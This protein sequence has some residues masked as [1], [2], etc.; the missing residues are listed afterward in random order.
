MP[1]NTNSEEVLELLGQGKIHWVTF[2]SS[3]TVKN[4]FAVV[5]P[6]ALDAKVRL[7]SIG[8]STS[9][10]I[11]QFGFIPAVQAE[12]YTI[13]GLIEAILSHEKSIKE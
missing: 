8:P 3:S 9:A 6:E 13:N 10:T 2:T 11:K 12:Q 4:F 1:D 7:A 5:K